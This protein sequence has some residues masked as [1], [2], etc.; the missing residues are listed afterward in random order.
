[1][2]CSKDNDPILDDTEENGIEEPKA[3]DD[4][5]NLSDEVLD[6]VSV[7]N[8]LF[9][10]CSSTAELSKHLNDIKSTKNV[11]D[12][13]YDS[14]SFFVKT[15]KG[16]TVSFFYPPKPSL[17]NN[18]WDSHTSSSKQKETPEG[19]NVCIL[20]GVKNDSDYSFL[21]KYL[22][23]LHADFECCNFYATCNETP[24]L[25]FFLS[26]ISNYDLIFLLTHGDYDEKN[27]LHWLFTSD[28]LYVFSENQKLDK[29][30]ESI[31]LNK[32][33]ELTNGEKYPNDEV[34]ISIVKETRNDKEVAVA[35]IAISDK[36]IKNRMIRLKDNAIVFNVACQ[37]LKGNTAMAENFIQKGAR[38]YLGYNETNNVGHSA[39]IQ[40]FQNMLDANC[41]NQSLYRID[42]DYRTNV[43]SP[44]IT[45]E[46][47]Y[48]PCNI[49]SDTTHIVWPYIVEIEDL[50]RG[51][52]LIVTLK[53]EVSHLTPNYDYQTFGFTFSSNNEAK[54]QPNNL[55][56]SKDSGMFELSNEDSNQEVLRAFGIPYEL[57]YEDH[58]I[59][60]EVTVFHKAL[61]KSNGHQDG[62]HTD[63]GI[64]FEYNTSYY[65]R[66]FVGYNFFYSGKYGDDYLLTN[67]T[68]LT[69]IGDVYS[70]KTKTLMDLLCPD[71][72]HPHAI[73]LALPSGTKWA[74]CDLGPSHP[75]PGNPGKFY[76]WGETESKTIFSRDNYQW[77]VIEDDFHDYY[78]NIGDNI[79]GT[80]YDAAHVNWGGA[81]RMPTVA[82]AKELLNY[83]AT[84]RESEFML[85][86]SGSNYNGIVFFNNGSYDPY[87]NIG[88]GTFDYWTSMISPK[89]PDYAYSFGGLGSIED[90][91]ERYYG[92]KIRPV[93][94]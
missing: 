77:I 54:Y 39:G 68:V 74:C 14:A 76:S 16:K 15:K 72:N 90:I 94:K 53:G 43:L 24:S 28:E 75:S 56:Y 18:N 44:Q 21:L 11:E 65:T 59:K 55:L 19:R 61:F 29:K 92:F 5:D 81:W 88:P 8:P 38:C 58:K 67:D 6:I 52:N 78:E 31:I 83:V 46:L 36:F 70:F 47:K 4:D 12:A 49:E 73:D 50:S 80:S 51:G 27:N 45:A 23:S 82:Q 57:K 85:C 10:K 60:F 35:K 62:C 3:G 9:L 42:Y 66:P 17:P 37:S 93:Y 89:G 20:N 86:L 32:Y 79:A 71:N 69:S 87:Y 40:F 1:M 13:W 63:L 33:R 25:S 48:Y 91:F 2:S 7:V 64:D 30:I 84:I 41:I 34:C 26:S 22:E